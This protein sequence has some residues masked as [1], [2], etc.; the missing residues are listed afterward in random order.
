MPKFDI[1]FVQ[2]NEGGLV[3]DFQLRIVSF[4]C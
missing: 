4:Q 1:L 3:I 2:K